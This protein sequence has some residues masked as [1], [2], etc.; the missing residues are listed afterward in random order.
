M[1][2]AFLTLNKHLLSSL[3][4][5]GLTSFS[6]SS[7]CAFLLQY[8]WKKYFCMSDSVLQLCPDI[9]PVFCPRETSDQKL[10][11]QG[12]EKNSSMGLRNGK[13]KWYHPGMGWN[14]LREWWNATLSYR[15]TK[16]S[17]SPGLFLHL[18][19]VFRKG[20]LKNE[21]RCLALYVY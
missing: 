1:Y 17:A 7:K 6:L 12:K 15:S 13:E 3:L 20:N 19:Q 10:S 2:V 16:C 21:N 18:V 8:T 11:T 14:P 9:Q 5:F 4:H